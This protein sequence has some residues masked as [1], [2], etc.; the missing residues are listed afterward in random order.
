MKGV[1]KR[2]VNRLV[3]SVG[4]VPEAEREQEKA[5]QEWERNYKKRYGKT[6]EEQ[7]RRELD[8]FMRE[9]GKY[10]LAD[11]FGKKGN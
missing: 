4:K 5:R 11:P 2:L 1:I 3:A 10:T 8:E 7:A 6:R 9:D